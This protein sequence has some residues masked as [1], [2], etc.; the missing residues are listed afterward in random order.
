MEDVSG[1]LKLHK[2]KGPARLGGRALSNLVPEYYAPGGGGACAC[3]GGDYK[4]GLTGR[5]KKFFK[6]SKWG[7]LGGPGQ[8]G[9]D[10]LGP[11]TRVARARQRPG[12]GD[13]AAGRAA[14]KREENVRAH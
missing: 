4:L 11:L 13:M 12:S 5:R 14:T 6:K 10:P 1:K 7:G 9:R 2:C 3:D 8:E